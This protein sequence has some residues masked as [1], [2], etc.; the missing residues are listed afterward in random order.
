MEIIGVVLL[1]E[2]KACDR[3][4][5][6]ILLKNVGYQT[7]VAESLDEARSILK[8]KQRFK[9]DAAFMSDETMGRQ[10]LDFAKW[11]KKNHAEI[12]MTAASCRASDE[13]TF[14]ALGISFVLKPIVDMKKV[15][16][17]LKPN[18]DHKNK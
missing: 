1:I 4:V 15:A 14:R 17:V 2:P 13:E 9:I 11:M 18:Q 8:S 5:L 3:Q 12:R 7:I 16:M 6:P 10:H